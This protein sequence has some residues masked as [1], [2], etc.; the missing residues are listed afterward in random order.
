MQSPF[1]AASNPASPYGVM[2]QMFLTSPPNQHPASLADASGS[3]SQGQSTEE[4]GH[5]M[6]QRTYSMGNVGPY[7]VL[8]PGAFRGPFLPSDQVS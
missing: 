5:A 7:G 4:R 2:A 8:T 1:V 3:S 6:Q